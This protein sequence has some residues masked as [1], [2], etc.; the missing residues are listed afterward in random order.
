MDA[1]S[2]L[3]FE[4][5]KPIRNKL[6]ELNIFDTLNILREYALSQ[7]LD[8]KLRFLH[9]VEQ[10][11]VNYIMP[12]ELDFL[13]VNSIIYSSELP[14]SKSISQVYLRGKILSLIEKIESRIHKEGMDEDVW[15]WLNSYFH[16]QSKQK[17]GHVFEQI[18]RYYTIFNQQEFD[19]HFKEK[20]GISYKIFILCS[21]W[22]YSCFS[23]KYSIPVSF[24][25]SINDWKIQ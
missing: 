23:K 16:N 2:S 14:S 24:I 13:I 10:G 18:Y 20:L 25:L 6:R 4:N 5:F 7:E 8:V 17:S 15:L 21:F 11:K 19:N 3:Y 1:N 9:N 22:L 12:N